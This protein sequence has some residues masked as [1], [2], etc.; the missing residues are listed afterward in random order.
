MKHGEPCPFLVAVLM[1]LSSDYGPAGLRGSEYILC[2]AKGNLLK[3]Y[4]LVIVFLFITSPM[5]RDTECRPLVFP[6]L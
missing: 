6:F 1:G 3:V 2:T 4:I 5:L